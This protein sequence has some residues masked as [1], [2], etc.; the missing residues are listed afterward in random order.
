MS[1]ALLWAVQRKVFCPLPLDCQISP[2]T[3][4]SL[5]VLPHLNRIRILLVPVL[6]LPDWWKSCQWISSHGPQKKRR[7]RPAS[8]PRNH[9]THT[10]SFRGSSIHFPRRSKIPSGAALTTAY[11]RCTCRVHCSNVFRGDSQ[12]WEEMVRGHLAS[13]MG[14]SVQLVSHYGNSSTPRNKMKSTP[15]VP[16]I[17]I[18]IAG[19][20]LR[21]PLVASTSC[22]H[23][24]W[25]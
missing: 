18:V 11:G 8:Q 23:C 2:S 17:F 16:V 13:I 9:P 6:W 25:D 3:A 20:K 22:F 4:A 24:G 21:T 12:S 5:M 19:A 10:S 1:S 15:A 7:P 14:F